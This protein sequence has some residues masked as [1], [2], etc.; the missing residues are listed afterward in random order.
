MSFKNCRI[1]GHDIDADDYHA[2][3]IKRGDPAFP[4]SPSVLKDFA[5][6]PQRWLD[7]Y[8][9]KDSDSKDWGQLVDCLLLTPGQFPKKYAIRPDTYPAPKSHAK[10]KAGLISEGDPLPWNGNATFCDEW[11]TSIVEMGRKPVSVQDTEDAT[12]AVK[13]ILA[14][15]ILADFLEGSKRQ[16]LVEGE[17]H[18]QGVIVPVR[19]LIDVVPD[20]DSIYG[21]CL[22]DGKTSTNAGPSFRRHV[23]QFGY[24]VQGAFDLDM[25]NAAT[26]EKRSEWC[27]LV[28]ENYPPFAIGRKALK[29]ECFG[30]TPFLELGRKSYLTTLQLYAN[31]LK[32]GKWPGYDDGE[33][34]SDGWTYLEPCPWMEGEQ[35]FNTRIEP[36]TP[37]PYE[38][39]EVIP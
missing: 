12:N 11:K 14:D 30:P 35:L 33:E 15:P 9:G 7:G 10:V 32:S 5:P 36:S 19:C 38:C 22:G 6:N 20:K 18:H 24:H 29:D 34:S 4:I 2:V 3:D 26:G 21:R 27:F 13:K 37:D 17:F 8:K 16:V 31:C 39:N 23:W 28:Q 1:V 25:F